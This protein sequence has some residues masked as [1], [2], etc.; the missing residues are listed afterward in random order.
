MELINLLGN[1]V[2]IINPG[3]G[4]PGISTYKY[5]C[6]DPSDLAGGS[7]GRLP[8]SDRNVRGNGSPYFP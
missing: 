6:V 8:P 7:G 3:N 1:L 4:L 2:E 5:V